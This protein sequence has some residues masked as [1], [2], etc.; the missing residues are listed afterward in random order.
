[1]ICKFIPP[2]LT[3]LSAR[4]N[5]QG[6]PRLLPPQLGLWSTWRLFKLDASLPCRL[7]NIALAAAMLGIV[8]IGFVG[9][10]ISFNLNY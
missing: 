2:H 3:R 5:L 10:L 9:K 7:W 1:M 8:W 4:C 6:S